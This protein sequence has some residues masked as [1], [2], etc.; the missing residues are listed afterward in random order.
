[1]TYA[2]RIKQEFV[3]VPE[4]VL[5][6]HGAVSRETVEAMAQGVRKLFGAEL[7]L[8]V[9]GIA[10]PEGG[11]PE[12]PVGTVWIAASLG[13][14]VVSEKLALTGARDEIRQRAAWRLLV[15]GLRLLQ[16]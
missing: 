11:T 16:A 6:E 3:A 2:N 13:E 4:D 14:R 9:S 15:A 8:A 12:K 7:G 1:V 10:G 5:K